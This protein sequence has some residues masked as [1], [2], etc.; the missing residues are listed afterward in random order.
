MCVRANG[1]RSVC[2]DRCL[3]TIF[4]DKGNFMRSLNIVSTLFH[5]PCQGN[6][7]LVVLNRT[8]FMLPCARAFVSIYTCFDACIWSQ[9]ANGTQFLLTRQSTCSSSHFPSR[10]SMLIF[11]DVVIDECECASAARAKVETESS[12]IER[13]PSR[14]LIN[15]M[16]NRFSTCRDDAND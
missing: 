12:N 7:V 15:R 10:I 5:F 13:N 4:S 16:L 14:D 1:S 11:Y 6:D 9:C 3:H 8:Q 2:A